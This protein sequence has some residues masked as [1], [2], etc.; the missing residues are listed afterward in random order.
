MGWLV[1]CLTISGFGQGQK[2]KFMVFGDS[3]GTDTTDQINT[4]ILAE[5]AKAATNENPAF[6]L[7][8][9]DLVYAGNTA[10]FQAWSNIMS[11][12]YQAGISVYPVLGNHDD[13]SD[14]NAFKNFFGPMLP[15]NGPPGEIGRTYAITRSN[16][17]VLALD[18]YVNPGRVNT[19]WVASVLATNTRPHVFAMGHQPA[20]KVNHDDCLDDYPANRNAFWNSLSN[21][22]CRIYFAG[23]DHFYDHMRLDDGDGDSRNDLHQFIVGTAGAPLSADS[24]PYN[25]DNSGWTPARV[26]HEQQ[27]GYVIV[28]ID[29][30]QATATWHHRVGSNAYA[31]TAEIFAYDARPL[32]K[33]SYADGRLMMKWSGAATLQ[34]ASELAGTFTDVPGAAPPYTVTNTG[35]SAQFYRLRVP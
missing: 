31:A 23:H 12:V 2:W 21:A 25:G 19:N 13:D 7:V 10:A 3:R 16:V 32:I 28:E 8:P 5:L 34:S 26:L 4:N 15:T 20:F 35:S 11:P 18:T 6:V 17:L 9:G 33:A 30:Y 24:Y 27:Y 1:T 14:P 29:G 22:H